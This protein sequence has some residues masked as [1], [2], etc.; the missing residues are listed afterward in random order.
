[1]IAR[2]IYVWVKTNPVP[3]IRKINWNSG[4][5]FIWVGSKGK[6]KLKNFKEQ[7]YMSSYY[8][9]PNASAHKETDHP[10]EKPKRLIRHLIEVNS[11]PGEVVLDCFMGSGTVG[12]VCKELGRG[13]IGIEKDKEYFDI[14]RGRI[15]RAVF[16]KEM[17]E[18]SGMKG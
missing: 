7:K 12:A 2:T 4:T 5:E 17:A 9:S 8:I 18:V 14:A 15:E 6:S 1:M 11:N 13:F 10:A 3:S 16:Q